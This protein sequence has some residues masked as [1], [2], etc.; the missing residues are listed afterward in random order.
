MLLKS[1]FFLVM[2]LIA[3]IGIN[4]QTK[5]SFESTDLGASTRIFYLS[6]VVVLSGFLS[7]CKF[8]QWKKSKSKG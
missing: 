6:G 3:F 1:L 8:Q 2:V 7:F 4:I 5:R